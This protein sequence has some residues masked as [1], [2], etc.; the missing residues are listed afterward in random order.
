MPDWTDQVADAIDNAVGV[1]RDK[2]VVPARKVV[3]ALTRGIMVG[4]LAAAT[5]LLA[6]LASF[7]GVVLLAQGEVWLA[8]LVL[9]TIFT[10]VGLGLVSLSRRSRG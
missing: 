9:G 4:L 7:R 5:A 2:T 3:S 6:A 8:H 10:G 1:V